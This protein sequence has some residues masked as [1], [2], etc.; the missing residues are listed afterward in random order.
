M[1]ESISAASQGLVELLTHQ[2]CCIPTPQK[3]RYGEQRRYSVILH[4]TQHRNREQ[5]EE[6]RRYRSSSSS[7]QQ[8]Q[9]QMR[10]AREREREEMRPTVESSDPLLSLSMI[11][12]S[13][14]KKAE[15]ATSN[16]K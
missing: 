7:F 5:D 4:D 1:V 15:K 8:A 13:F 12:S 14:E 9:L 6:Y 10:R 2:E 3:K 16:D 11:Y